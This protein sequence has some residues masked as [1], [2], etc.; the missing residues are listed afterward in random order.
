[1]KLKSLLH[2]LRSY[3]NRKRYKFY[4]SPKFRKLMHSDPR[5]ALDIYWQVQMQYPLNWKNPKTLNEKNFWLE[6]M[7]DTTLWTEYSDKYLVRKHIND[8]GLS[9]ILTKLYGAW[10]NADDIDFDSLPDK[11]V[12]KCNHDCGSYII[13]TDKDKLDK[14]SARKKLQKCLSQKFGYNTCE[15]HYL[16]IHP[17][18]LA[19]EL[20]E[21]APS[22]FQSSSLIDYK[23]FCC[24][25]KAQCC[26]VCYDR[27]EKTAVYDIYDIKDWNR[28]KNM[29]DSYL[30]QHFKDLVPKPKNLTEMVSIAETLAKG[31]PF[32]RVDLYNTG[33]ERI[34]FGEMT[35]TPHGG[36][37]DCFNTHAQIELGALITLP[38]T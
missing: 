27:G 9:Y 10:D 22:Q 23:F 31:F 14:D 7:T 2:P 16:R 37:Q 6:G 1:M 36:I 20:I 12:L 26:M 21:N 33:N 25:G 19:E 3:R 32:I 8:L 5:K 29:S 35:F 28:Y 38:K 15:P 13:V 24:D 30:K 18:I 11:F 4:L 17:L 34:V